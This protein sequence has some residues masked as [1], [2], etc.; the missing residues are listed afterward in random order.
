MQVRFKNE[1]HEVVQLV[2]AK[3]FFKKYKNDVN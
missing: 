3:S 2:K 1:L